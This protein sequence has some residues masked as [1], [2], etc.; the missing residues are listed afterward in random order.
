M[1]PSVQDRQ[2]LDSWKAIALHLQRDV[3]TAMRWAH[4]DGLPVHRIGEGR[5]RAVYAYRDEIDAWLAAQPLMP[6]PVPVPEVEDIAG[7]RAGAAGRTSWPT[8]RRQMALA[9]VVVLGVSLAVLAAVVSTGPA[10]AAIARAAVMGRDLVAFDGRGRE[11]WRHEISPPS[12]VAEATTPHLV[13]WDAG[14]PVE[15]LLPERRF[16]LDGI[17]TGSLLLVRGDGRLGWRRVLDDRVRFGGVEYGPTWYPS[18]IVTFRVGGDWRIAAAFHHHTWWPSIVT[19]FTRDGRPAGAFVN[20]GWIHTLNVSRDGRYLLAGGVSNAFDGAVLAVLDASAPSG[21]SPADGGVLPGCD[22]CQHGSP[23]AYFV[24]PWSDVARP[25][26][27]P[28]VVVQVS[29][30]GQIGLRAAQRVPRDGPVPEIIVTLSPALDVVHG[31]TSDGFDAMHALLE[32]QGQLD[33][34]F[35]RCPWQTPAVRRW[36]PA[37][38]WE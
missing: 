3:R 13:Q 23:A 16:G 24:V 34:P 15:V 2:R 21:A 5:R 8:G 4:S 1:A 10:S 33:H 12:D 19:A 14:G 37:R 28:A 32:R 11:L 7:Q 35:A 31:A 29:A 9:G 25:A 36:T 30:D 17:G 6:Q 18:S 26:D 22:N 38:G 27:T 20:A